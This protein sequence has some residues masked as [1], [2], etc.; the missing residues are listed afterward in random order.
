MAFTLTV[1][2]GKTPRFVLAIAAT[3]ACEYAE[4]DPIEFMTE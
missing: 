2:A 4:C 1:A 3:A